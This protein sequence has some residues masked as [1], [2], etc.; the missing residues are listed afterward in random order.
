MSNLST[1]MADALLAAGN[2]AGNASGQGQ[3]LS[4]ALGEETYAIGIL[5][6]KEIIEFDKLTQVPGMPASVRGVINLRGMVVPVIDL[7]H[8]LWA[9]TGRAQTETTR[10]SCVV[11]VEVRG[12]GTVPQTLGL[13]V[14]GVNEVLDLP[15]A[16]IQPAP[17]FGV[18][19]QGRLISGM[20][21]LREQFIL[22]LDA[23]KLVDATEL[24]NQMHEVIEAQG[25]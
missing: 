13:L 20:G 4:F 22:I 21:K 15:A 7:A 11:I 17:S 3:Y 8:R 10:R 2:A 25:Q 18:G 16:D 12:E 9:G 6:I 24:R 1:Q 5:A 19:A 23:A 14:D